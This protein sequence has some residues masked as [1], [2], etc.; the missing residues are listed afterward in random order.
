MFQLHGFQSITARARDAQKIAYPAHFPGPQKVWHPTSRQ[1]IFG[2]ALPHVIKIYKLC[3]AT[4]LTGDIS[5]P[6]AVFARLS[7]LIF[8]LRAY[9]HQISVGQV[10]ADRPSKETLYF[11]WLT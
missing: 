2:P 7:R 11:S 4:A 3:N 10:S 5:S 9:M 8:V 6:L 1:T